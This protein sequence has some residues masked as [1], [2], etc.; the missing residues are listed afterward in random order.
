MRIFALAAVISA[1]EIIYT[2]PDKQSY[3]TSAAV[4]KA[5]ATDLFK[6]RVNKIWS[7]GLASEC[8]FVN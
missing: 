6:E 4:G 5:C 2:A 3:A 7:F 8:I 1:S